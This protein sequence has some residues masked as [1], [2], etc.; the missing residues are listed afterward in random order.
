MTAEANRDGIMVMRRLD[1]KV[2][3]P[4]LRFEPRPSA[5]NGK[6]KYAREDE[7]QQ[8]ATIVRIAPPQVWPLHDAHQPLQAARPEPGWRTLDRSGLEIDRCSQ[9]SA[10][11][12]GEALVIAVQP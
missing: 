1:Q 8:Y 7:T 9:M 4:A 11:R 2:L 12:Y 3:R 5:G 10:Y 6:R